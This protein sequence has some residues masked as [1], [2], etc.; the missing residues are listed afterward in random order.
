MIPNTY[1]QNW[2]NGSD[3]TDTGT[4]RP[5]S[6]ARAGRAFRGGSWPA[7]ANGFTLGVMAASTT[8]APPNSTRPRSETPED[9]RARLDVP[10][11]PA[12]RAALEAGLASARR[13]EFTAPLPS[14]AQYLADDED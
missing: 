12:A 13:G 10:L 6:R 7:R 4:R 11:S 3:R 2:V 5:L 1:P 9:A 8:P 14:Y